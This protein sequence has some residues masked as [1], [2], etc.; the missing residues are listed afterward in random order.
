MNIRMPFSA[1]WFWKF[2]YLRKPSKCT[3]K[4]YRLAKRTASPA[5][6][7]PGIEVWEH[8][9]TLFVNAGRRNWRFRCTSSSF[10]QYRRKFR[11]SSWK[12][13]CSHHGLPWA[14]FRLRE[15]PGSF[16]PVQALDRMLPFVKMI[17]IFPILYKCQLLNGQHRVLGQPFVL[18]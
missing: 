5:S 7:W 1:S 15:V 6:R 9:S 11:Q 8:R 3:K 10:L 16:I 13:P 2:F 17:L 18:F 14:H 4:L 12:P